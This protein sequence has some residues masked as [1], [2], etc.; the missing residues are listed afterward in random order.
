MVRKLY[1]HAF[2][3]AECLPLQNEDTYARDW[4]HIYRLRK[5]KI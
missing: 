1:M 5:L 3:V 4:T 2:C